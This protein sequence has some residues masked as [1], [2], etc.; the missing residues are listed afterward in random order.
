MKR[1]V[2]SFF[3]FGA[4]RSLE[5]GAYSTTIIFLKKKE[6]KRDGYKGNYNHSLFKLNKIILWLCSNVISFFK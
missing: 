1:H 3:F 2:Y 6:K 5:S 4:G